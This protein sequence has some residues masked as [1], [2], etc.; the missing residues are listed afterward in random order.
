MNLIQLEWF[1]GP[2]SGQRWAL[3][4]TSR[5]IV[6][7]TSSSQPPPGL[8]LSSYWSISWILS[9]HWSI[10]PPETPCWP[11]VITISAPGRRPSPGSSL[12]SSPP[13]CS[14][15]RSG[16]SS[17]TSWPRH[18]TIIFLQNKNL[19]KNIVGAKKLS[20][21]QYNSDIQTPTFEAFASISLNAW[22]SPFW[23][24]LKN[25]EPRHISI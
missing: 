3:I 7:M 24:L 23:P 10:H 2:I 14:G 6:M 15:S 12:S 20:K 17:G 5:Q 1:K 9:S 21:L 8:I 13:S 25:I 19:Q 22:A 18:G 11:C 16:C 4:S